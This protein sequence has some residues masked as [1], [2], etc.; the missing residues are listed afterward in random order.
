MLVSSNTGDVVS[1]SIEEIKSGDLVW[2]RNELSG[3]QGFKPVETTFV[4][5]TDRLI[6]LSYHRASSR[7]PGS[8]RRGQKGGESSDDPDGAASIVGTLPE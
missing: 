5:E 3:E 7:T 4:R 6:H 2:S 8:S 1:K